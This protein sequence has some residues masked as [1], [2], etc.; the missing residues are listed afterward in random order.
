M[1]KTRFRYGLALLAGALA[2]SL[3]TQ[4]APVAGQD[5]DDRWLPWIGCWAPLAENAEAQDQAAADQPLVCFRPA[6]GGVEMFAFADGELQSSEEIYTDGRSREVSREGCSGTERAEFSQDGRRVFLSGEM[7]CGND[8]TRTAHGLMSLTSPTHWLDV[9]SVEVEGE[10]MAWV[11]RYMLASPEAIQE[12]GVVDPAS[13]REMAVRTAR[14]VV[15]RGIDADDVVE[16]TQR[17]DAKAVE[18]WV[19]ETGEPFEL[20]AGELVRLADAGVPGSVTDV[21]IATSYPHRFSIDAEGRAAARELTPSQ[22]AYARYPIGAR[23]GYRPL[24]WDPFYYGYSPFYR[25]YYG[26]GGYWGGY[27]GYYGGYYGYRPTVVIVEPSRDSGRMVGGRGYVPSSGSATGRSA[28]PR[29][30]AGSSG[31]SSSG[32]TA[33]PRRGGEYQFSPAASRPSAPVARS[34]PVSTSRP[35]ASTGRTARRRGGGD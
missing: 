23:Y 21:M 3:A 1:S 30:S 26:Y 10:S 33:R 15:S 16:A 32:R 25:S 2:G 19:A 20:D 6:D 34:A 4:P 11:Q 31:S 27:G 7:S 14:M 22:R 18:A 28:Q 29:S 12:A 9:R 8:V 35:A 13:G 17:V 24:F 5:L